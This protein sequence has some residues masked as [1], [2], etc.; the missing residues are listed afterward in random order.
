[1]ENINERPVYIVDKTVKFCFFCRVNVERFMFQ[2]EPNFLSSQA[3]NSKTKTPDFCLNPSIR[4]YD[5][6]P[7][8]H[9]RF[10]TQPMH[11]RMAEI[12]RLHPPPALPRAPRGSP[13]RRYR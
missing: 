4:L 2:P 6:I 7:Q 12:P 9:I 13:C 8:G 11:P 5:S 3:E 1:M 10:P